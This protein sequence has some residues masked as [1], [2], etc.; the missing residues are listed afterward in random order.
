[1]LL[2]IKWFTTGNNEL[3]V[4]HVPPHLIPKQKLNAQDS[5][6]CLICGGEL[7]V[8]AMR[9]H[10]G[11][12]ILLALRGREDPKAIKIKVGADPCGFC[13]EEG[14]HTQLTEA[15]GVF[16]ITSDCQYHYSRM[17]YKSATKSTKAGPC[18]NVPIYCPLC[19]KS[20]SGNF[21]TIWKYNARYH[22]VSEHSSNSTALPEIPPQFTIDT[23]IRRQEEKWMGITAQETDDYREEYRIPD[24][25]DI[26]VLIESQK[27]QFKRERSGTE[28]TT[29]SDSHKSKYSRTLYK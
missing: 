15:H 29:G 22:L 13:G 7:K 4:Q 1:M 5:I 21:R 19:P 25:D 26:D 24:S 11:H 6:A 17:N 16:K 9:N 28:S 2:L 20:A 8:S 27:H 14:C 10:V 23:F 12:H 3:F 18:T